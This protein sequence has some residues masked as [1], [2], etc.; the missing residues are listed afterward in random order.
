MCVRLFD[1]TSLLTLMCKWPNM[2]DEVAEWLR[3]WTANPMCSARVGSNPILVVGFFFSVFV[4]HNTAQVYLS[5]GDVTHH[6]PLEVASQ[7][8][9]VLSSTTQFSL[10]PLS[11]KSISVLTT[12]GK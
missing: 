1:R 8:F 11:L 12:V 7:H 3:R 9:S 4:I 2:F 5:P 6:M 10:N